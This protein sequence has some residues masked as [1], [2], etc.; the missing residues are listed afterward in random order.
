MTFGWKPGELYLFGSMIESR[1]NVFS[2]WP[3]F[4]AS[5]TTFVSRLG[6]TVPLAPAAD[7]VWQVEQ[8]EAPV[9]TTLPA[10]ALGDSVGEE[11]LE[12]LEEEDEFDPP[13]VLGAG[14]DPAPGMPGWVAFGGGVPTGDGPLARWP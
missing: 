8:P 13:L 14:P 5:G 4:L 10:W 12:L 7:S 2:G 11:P 3:A 6:P 9:N 1:M